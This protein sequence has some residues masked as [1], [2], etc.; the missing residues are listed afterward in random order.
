MTKFF[1]NPKSLIKTKNV[2]IGVGTRINGEILIHGKDSVSIGNYC[3]F[4]YCFINIFNKDL[5]SNF[6]LSLA[7]KC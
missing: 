7:C 1:L 4:G 3:A 2:K 5:F 6:Y